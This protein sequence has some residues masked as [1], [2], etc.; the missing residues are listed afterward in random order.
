MHVGS[1]EG[2]VAEG[3]GFELSLI[4]PDFRLIET[5]EIAEVAFSI[6]A[7]AGVVKLSVGE[8]G[9]MI[10]DGMADGAVAPV[11]V[12]EDGQAADRRGGERLLVAAVLVLI[13]G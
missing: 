10:I 3:G 12:F 8:E 6:H 4:R 1:T 5:A 11:R 7:G 13:K 9:V 2:N